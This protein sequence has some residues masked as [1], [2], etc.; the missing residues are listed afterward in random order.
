[1]SM[2]KKIVYYKDFGAVGD[3]VHEDIDAIRAC[4]EYANAN[5]RKG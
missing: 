3:G 4:H 2:E 5:G 1:M